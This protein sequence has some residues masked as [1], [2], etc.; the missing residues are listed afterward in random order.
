MDQKTVEEAKDYLGRVAIMESVDNAIKF[1]REK[2]RIEAI[3]DLP[4][5]DRQVLLDKSYD[6]LA[7]Q[8]GRNL[9]EK[10]FGLA[11]HTIAELRQEE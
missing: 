7:L 10:S 1:L 5:Q 3:H 9:M 8:L 2:S 11:R 4:V 6:N